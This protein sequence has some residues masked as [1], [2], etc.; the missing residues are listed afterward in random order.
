M[1]G[2]KFANDKVREENIIVLNYSFVSPQR[3][4]WSQYL[5]NGALSLRN[6]FD[7]IILLYNTI[8]NIQI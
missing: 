5:T 4:N 8:D 6:C 7:Y 1:T 2:D 3:R